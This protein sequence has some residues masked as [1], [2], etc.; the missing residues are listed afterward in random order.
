MQTKRGGWFCRTVFARKSTASYFLSGVLL[1]VL[2]GRWLTGASAQSVSSPTITKIAAVGD[3]TP[4]GGTFAFF[5]P[6]TQNQRGDAAF[7]ATIEGG[8][9][10][11]AIFLVSGGHLTKVAATKDATPLGELSPSSSPPRLNSIGEV[12]F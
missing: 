10:S 12:A 2:V 7:S 3:A 1:A 6:P 4:L 8:A 5:S 9:A 11:P